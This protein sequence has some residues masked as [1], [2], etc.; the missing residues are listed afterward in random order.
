M[1]WIAEHKNLHVASMS[2]SCNE[3]R[4]LRWSFL[5][6]ILKLFLRFIRHFE[7]S[8]MRTILLEMADAAQKKDIPTPK[9]RDVGN[10][11][12]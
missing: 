3:N 6:K 5:P 12:A 9:R 8:V 1:F 2:C 4:I 7:T 11:I 10:V